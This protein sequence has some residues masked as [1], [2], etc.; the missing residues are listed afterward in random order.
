MSKTLNIKKIKPKK[1]IPRKKIPNLDETI[2]DKLIKIYPYEMI[3]QSKAKNL[4]E[5]NA[6]S[7]IY[8]SQE[9]FSKNEN[10]HKFK[11]DENGYYYFSA[12][13]VKTSNYKL[14]SSNDLDNFYNKLK[15]ENTFS[16]LT[17]TF[18]DI[19]KFEGMVFSF[20][21]P[22][23]FSFE[24]KN[25]K[26]M[27]FIQEIKEADVFEWDDSFKEELQLVQFEALS[28]KNLVV[29]FNNAKVLFTNRKIQE[30]MIFQ[31]NKNYDWDIIE[32][33]LTNVDQ[34]SQDEIDEIKY[35]LVEEDGEPNSKAFFGFNFFSLVNDFKILCNYTS[36]SL[37]QTFEGFLNLKT[38]KFKKTSKNIPCQ[39][40]PIK[41]TAI[42]D[43][44][45]I[46]MFFD[47]F[48]YDFVL[49]YYIAKKFENGNTLNATFTD[50]K[51]KTTSLFPSQEDKELILD[52]ITIT[53]A[54]QDN[55]NKF[56]RITDKN[57]ANYGKI[58]SD[59]KIGY[60]KLQILDV[61]DKKCLE[62]CDGLIASHMSKFPSF[63]KDLE[64]VFIFNGFV[65]ALS[66]YIKSSKN[67]A[68]G[69]N[70]FHKVV[71]P[72]YLECQLDGDNKI[73]Y[74]NLINQSDKNY[75][76]KSDVKFVIK[77]FY[78]KED[79]FKTTNNTNLIKLPIEGNLS[80]NKIIQVDRKVA[81]PK[82]KSAID[83]I[84]KTTNPGDI[85]TN[86]EALKYLWFITFAS[87]TTFTKIFVDTLQIEEI[88]KDK[89]VKVKLKNTPWGTFLTQAEVNK[90]IL[91]EQPGEIKISPIISIGNSVTWNVTI[92][93]NTLNL[94][95][96]NSFGSTSQILD[97]NFINSIS[98]FPD[99]QV[100]LNFCTPGRT[101][102]CYFYNEAAISDDNLKKIISK[103]FN[104]PT[105]TINISNNNFKERV[106]WRYWPKP[107]SDAY[108]RLHLIKELL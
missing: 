26:E 19:S 25:Q 101:G 20:G 37:N 53:A 34:L 95:N 58:D 31:I 63:E 42:D 55:F 72:W 24:I 51:Q 46:T 22:F 23:N 70:Q 97:E 36:Q 15:N 75:G 105:N 48:D 10:Y 27:F 11:K 87:N 62:I 35:S 73:D 16:V 32:N 50:S 94:S 78:F 66:Q 21:E 59:Y 7:I 71:L 91:E 98:S 9:N 69:N 52:L 74:F 49:P 88:V 12:L 96:P 43:N 5:E 61:V 60:S 64:R 8:V 80:K 40:I 67:V 2:P 100:P 3:N 82:I 29:D 33:F 17:N 47:W 102:I 13:Q 38:S 4:F 65:N 85:E 81:L 39:F 107:P 18:F 90:R 79:Y 41:T 57:N 1:S 76:V 54:F 84:E 56:P 14:V 77:S 106:Y 89:E 83:V 30:E 44:E 6:T 68:K 92:S 104:F 99:K 86:E 28:F 93:S 108:K 103:I 45:Q